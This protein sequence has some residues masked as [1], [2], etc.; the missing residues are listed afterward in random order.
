M[1][2]RTEQTIMFLI[3]LPSLTFFS[4]PAA[5]HPLPCWDGRKE[6][7][8]LI[9]PLAISRQALAETRMAINMPS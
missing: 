2:Q 4:K 1:A 8:M 3:A 9:S 5:H 6:N 7:T